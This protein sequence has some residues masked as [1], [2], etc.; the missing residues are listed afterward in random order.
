MRWKQLSNRCAYI[1]TRK[2]GHGQICVPQTP[3]KSNRGMK[4]ISI[5]NFL[6]LEYVKIQVDR[7]ESTDDDATAWSHTDN[8]YVFIHHNVKLTVTKTIPN[9]VFG[10]NERTVQYGTVRY[11]TVRYGTV[12][13]STVQYSTVQY[14]TVQ[15]GTV[16]YSTVRYST[17]HY[18]TVQKWIIIVS[19]PTFLFDFMFSLFCWKPKSKKSVFRH[20]A[21]ESILSLKLYVP[22]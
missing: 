16:Q 8:D 3:T 18:S 11:G 20:S 10:L 12:R 5:V 7:M 6:Y 13:Y 14:S 2:G 22:V 17:V 4:P 21:V 19:M 1:R 9:G 15:Y